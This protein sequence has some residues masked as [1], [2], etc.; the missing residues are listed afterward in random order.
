MIHVAKYFPN[1][2]NQNR[3]SETSAKPFFTLSS[4]STTCIQRKFIVPITIANANANSLWPHSCG[5]VV[6]ELGSCK[7]TFIRIFWSWA[8]V[9]RSPGPPTHNRL[10]HVLSLYCTLLGATKNCIDY[11]RIQKVCN[12][13]SFSGALTSCCIV[14]RRHHQYHQH[15][16]KQECGYVPTDQECTTWHTRWLHK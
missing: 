14:Y 4:C 5:W 1:M 11:P 7:F 13:V 9:C 12:R 15:H 2:L 16:A 8:L 3:K 10:Q 6:M